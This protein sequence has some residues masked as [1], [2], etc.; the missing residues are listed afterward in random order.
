M[1]S[2]A[3]MGAGGR[4]GSALV[5]AVK[6]FPNLKLAAAVEQPGHPM[7]GIDSGTVAGC[8]PTGVPVTSM[9]GP[10]AVSGGW[11]FFAG[12]DNYMYGWREVAP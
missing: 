10:V 7:V 12:Q 1:I 4:M 2:I 9:A 6:N 8:P 3:I 11:L 5:Q